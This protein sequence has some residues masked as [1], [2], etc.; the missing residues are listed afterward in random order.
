[1]EILLYTL[2]WTDPPPGKDENWQD[3]SYIAGGGGDDK[4]I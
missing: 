4:L 2:K 1:M 3:I